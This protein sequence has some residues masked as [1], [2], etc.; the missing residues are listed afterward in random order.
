MKQ[1]PND[2]RFLIPKRLPRTLRGLY[3]FHKKL[4]EE[5][6]YGEFKKRALRGAIA[7]VNAEI[8]K[9]VGWLKDN[10]TWIEPA[11]LALQILNDLKAQLERE[12][13]ATQLDV[14]VVHDTNELII[15]GLHGTSQSEEWQRY[16]RTLKQTRRTNMLHEPGW[17][18]E[19]AFAN[20]L[21]RRGQA[22]FMTFG[23]I[24]DP[25]GFDVISVPM[26]RTRVNWNKT[27]ARKRL[28]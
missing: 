4:R 15:R 20:E 2:V 25:H 12:L 1:R 18:Y 26:A 28:R 16:V 17:L 13:K 10:K 19:M 8:E 5:A 9:Y 3:G 7:S 14:E 23:T 6:I 22:A 24:F 27:V 11:K 21:E